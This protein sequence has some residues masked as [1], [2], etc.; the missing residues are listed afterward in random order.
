MILLVTIVVT[1]SGCT[2][3]NDY[4]VTLENSS[5]ASMLSTFS[6]QQ[7]LETITPYSSDI[8]N[9]Y[10]FYNYGQ[11]SIDGINVYYTTYSNFNDNTSLQGEL[12]FKK[13]G[14]WYSIY[15]DDISGNPNKNSIENE[16]SDK[17]N[18]I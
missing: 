3:S 4:N 17:I 2:S 7:A 11:K 14:K 1:I 13:N 9:G 5:D 18:S 6:D 12:Y 16:I 15:W 8:Q 10:T